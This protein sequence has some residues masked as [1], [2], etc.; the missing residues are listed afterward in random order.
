M[1][2]GAH[3][4][5]RE[6]FQLHPGKIG[7]V[8]AVAERLLAY[9]PPP[10]RVLDI[11]SGFGFLVNELRRRGVAAW[12]IE[13]ALL[14]CVRASPH[15]GSAR[16]CV[17]G[18]A[19][20]LSFTD[21][22]FD[23]VAC[24]DLIEHVADY[25][26]MLAECHRVLRPG[27]ALLVITLNAHGIAR[28]LLGRDWAWHQD[29]THRHLFSRRALA[30]ALR[31]AGFARVRVET[32]FNFHSVG[33]STPRLRPLQRLRRFVTVPWFGDAL[34]GLATRAPALRGGG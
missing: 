15:E 27:G 13:H 7:Y 12:G 18:D 10:R 14:A 31:A 6:Y 16:R 29:P 33:E 34:L 9:G 25:E 4:F 26:A 28:P 5:D 8:R 1:D 23:A 32:F 24:C 2:Y 21:G 3:Y 30:R 19:A 22:G 17:C 20:A 11:G